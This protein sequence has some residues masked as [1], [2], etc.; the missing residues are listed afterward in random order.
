MKIVHIITR[1]ILGGA[2]ENTLLSVIGLDAKPEY[3]VTLITGPALGP[4]GELIED[5]R[6][7]GVKLILVPEMRRSIN[8][9]LDLRTYRKLRRRLAEI[10]PAIVHTHSSK[11]GILGRLAAHRLGV[12]VIV[13]TI[14]GL[15]FH[16]YQSR[17][18]RRLFVAAERFAARRTHRIV[19]VCDAMIE[20]AV[21]AGVAPRDR[22]ET[23]YS[24]MRVEPFLQAGRGDRGAVRAEFGLAP[25]DLVIGQIARLMTLKGHEYILPIIPD[26]GREFP[27]AKFLF[28][29][30]GILRSRLEAE[31]EALGVRDRVVF[32]GLVPH[33][34]IPDVLSTMDLLI[35]ASLRE[36][37]ARVLPQALLAG[38]PVVSFD[39]D[40]AAEVVF[41]GETGYLAEPGSSASLLAE[42]RRMLA[43]PKAARAMAER[44]RRSCLE[45]FRHDRMVAHLDRIYQQLA[46][47][48]GLV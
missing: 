12:P 9:W 21:A 35:H 36:G 26:V 48:R 16:D 19:T 14:H 5:A 1:M 28:V 44:G 11:A 4:E 23:V 13:H 47:E 34:R 20:K 25:D 29:G 27:R 31:A 15:P 2:Q 41:S 32:A 38:V 42:I 37:L 43:D 17:L 6:R 46:A 22:F 30:D 18:E 40:G 45:R 8:P 10:R 33:H 39:I 24:G 7:A 3:D